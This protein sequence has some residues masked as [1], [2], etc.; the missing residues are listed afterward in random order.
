MD[1]F[2]HVPTVKEFNQ[3]S[4]KSSQWLIEA[5]DELLTWFN[6]VVDVP[7]VG[8]TDNTA[9]LDSYNYPKAY[10]LLNIRPEYLTDKGYKL[11]PTTTLVDDYKT[12]QMGLIYN[13]EVASFYVT[14]G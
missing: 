12:T 7:N 2:N 14:W 1:K 8:V 10:A 5:Q 13:A 4:T 6:Q 9:I 11:N 3:Q